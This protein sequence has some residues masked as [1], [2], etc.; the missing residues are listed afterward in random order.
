MVRK[1]EEGPIRPAADPGK[2]SVRISIRVKTDHQLEEVPVGTAEQ[3]CG[4]PLEEIGTTSPR[5]LPSS[6]HG[7]RRGHGML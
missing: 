2:H 3:G 4:K 7:A 5:S 1:N 6:L